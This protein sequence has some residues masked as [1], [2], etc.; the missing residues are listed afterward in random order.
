MFSLTFILLLYA[1]FC[2]Q[3]SL[4][5]NAN[6]QIQDGLLQSSGMD[7]TVIESL[8]LFRFSL[9]KGSRDG[10]ECAVCLAKFED[11]EILRLLPKC[12]HAFH[13]DCI[14]QW[15]EKHSTCPLC[16]QK[17][18]AE[19]LS[20]LQYSNSLRFLCNQ[21]E[22][23]SNNTLEIYVEREEKCNRSSRFISIGSSFRKLSD[24]GEKEEE[25]PIQ[26]QNMDSKFNH[27]IVFVLKNRWSN[28]TCSDLVFLNSE[29]LTD[30]SSKRFSSSL[31]L[32]NDKEF[33]KALETKIDYYE[34]RAMINPKNEKRSM[35]EIIVHP[36]FKE[37]R[38]TD[39]SAPAQNNATRLWLPIATKT[40]HCNKMVRMKRPV[41][42]SKKDDIPPLALVP[43]EDPPKK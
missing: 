10:L 33:L 35:S 23:S 42:R 34:S 17:V 22:E 15:L 5:R 39:Y 1:K 32:R 36:R 27:K 2:H 16:R 28:V 43:Y 37:L 30:V 8:P 3:T 26:Q 11:I 6:R 13:I 29:M 12:K 14:D 20:H 21:T 38:N 25:L 9:L 7:K 40:L 31:D 19:D 4:F 18:G 41:K 24:K